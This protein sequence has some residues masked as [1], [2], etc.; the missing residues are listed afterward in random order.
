V[1]SEGATWK[2]HRKLL[3]PAFHFAALERLHSVFDA[4]A[5]RLT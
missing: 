4:A 5:G 1:T 3:S 2:A